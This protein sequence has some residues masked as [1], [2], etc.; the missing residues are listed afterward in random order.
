MN[1]LSGRQQPGQN[2]FPVDRRVPP[3]LGWE[4]C[5]GRAVSPPFDEFLGQGWSPP[6]ARLLPGL[7]RGSTLSVEAP[8][9]G[10]MSPLS[11]WA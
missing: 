5:E 1:L 8:R 3:P 6:S 9:T 4:L 11:A 7:V 2:C 10:T